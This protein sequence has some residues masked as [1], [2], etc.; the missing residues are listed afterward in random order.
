M[1]RSQEKLKVNILGNKKHASLKNLSNGS[2]S[3][4]YDPETICRLPPVID[5]TLWRGG[6]V[7]IIKDNKANQDFPKGGT[8][9][10]EVVGGGFLHLLWCTDILK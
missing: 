6:G 4:W 2:L 5:P 3:N 7:D 1:S 9:L 10:G 8:R